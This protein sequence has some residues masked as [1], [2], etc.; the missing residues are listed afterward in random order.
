[1]SEKPEGKNENIIEEETTGTEAETVTET[2]AETE[3]VKRPVPKWLK[4][5][6][7]VAAA[8]LVLGG[9]GGYVGYTKYQ[10]Y[11]AEQNRIAEDD[12]LIKQMAYTLA[13]DTFH[14]HAVE[15]V[16]GGTGEAVADALVDAGID[17]VEGVNNRPPYVEITDANRAHFADIQSVLISPDTGMVEVSVD[18][19]AKALPVSDD[20]YYYLFSKAIYQNSITGEPIAKIEKDVDFV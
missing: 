13:L 8:L 12:A 6:G 19:P 16:F 15:D 2:G 17:T 14:R 9:I 10:A 1:M 11:L 5:T 4:V 3:T 18:I 20:G 7:I